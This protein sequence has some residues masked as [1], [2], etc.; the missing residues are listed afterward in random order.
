MDTED[1]QEQMKKDA[2]V[3]IASVGFVEREI[4]RNFSLL[5]EAVNNGYHEDVK[6]LEKRILSLVAKVGDENKNMDDFMLK[7]KKVIQN[8]KTAIL[9][10]LK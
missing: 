5:E 1:L 6:L 3:I 8:E 9:S 2:L 10:G 7:Y 4:E